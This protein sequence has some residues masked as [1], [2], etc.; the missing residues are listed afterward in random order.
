L[1]DLVVAVW[2]S[3]NAVISV[4]VVARFGPCY[5]GSAVRL[6]VFVS[7]KSLGST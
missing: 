7:N 1:D 5:I 6:T 4:K 2:L 3:S